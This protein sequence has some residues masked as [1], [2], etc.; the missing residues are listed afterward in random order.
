MVTLSLAQLAN[1]LLTDAVEPISELRICPRIS[2][3]LHLSIGLLFAGKT[4]NQSNLSHKVFES[5]PWLYIADP[6]HLCQ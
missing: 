4:P 1:N 6:S 2:C 3:R 5:L